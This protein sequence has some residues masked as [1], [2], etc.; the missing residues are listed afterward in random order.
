MGQEGLC[1]DNQV[2]LEKEKRRQSNIKSLN[3]LVWKSEKSSELR[4]SSGVSNWVT[5]LMSLILTEIHFPQL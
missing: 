3:T 2:K 4:T 5:L 1:G